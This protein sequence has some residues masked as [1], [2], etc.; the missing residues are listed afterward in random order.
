MRQFNRRA[1]GYYIYTYMFFDVYVY[2]WSVVF[3]VYFDDII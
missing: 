2:M 1:K 3:L